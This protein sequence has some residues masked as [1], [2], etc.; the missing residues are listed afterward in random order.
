MYSTVGADTERLLP[1]RATAYLVDGLDTNSMG[2]QTQ[3]RRVKLDEVSC[4]LAITL[5]STT[6]SSYTSTQEPRLP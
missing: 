2:Q 4:L 1:E 5:N 6:G 3:K